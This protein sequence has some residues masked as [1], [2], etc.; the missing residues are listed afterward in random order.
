MKLVDKIVEASNRPRSTEENR[1]AK[2]LPVFVFFFLFPT[3][4]FL[5]PN[6]VL[7]KWL[8]LPT[9][10]YP[11]ARAIIGAIL[12]VVGVVF[13]LWT[14][15]AQREIGKGTPMPLMATQKL[16]IQK[17]YSYC[18]NPLAFGLLNLY[19]GI[20]IF[21]GSITSLAMV[22]IFAV[23]ILSYIKYVEEKELKKRYGEEYVAYKQSTPFLIPR[24]SGK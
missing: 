6:F 11:F 24:G 17:P 12:I 4:L 3:L 8:H 14:L 9:I 1:T 19:V 15:K 21:I 13:L 16:V 20:S 7:D 18:R 22:L 10:P 23:L 5:I 2:I